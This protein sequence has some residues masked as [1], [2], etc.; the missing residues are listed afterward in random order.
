MS[1]QETKLQAIADAIKAK[2]G[3]TDTIQASQFASK[4]GE[5]QLGEVPLPS[6]GADYTTG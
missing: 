5:I 1:T 2:L 6:W 3:T 4:I